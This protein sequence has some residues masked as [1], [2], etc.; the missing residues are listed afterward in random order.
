MWCESPLFLQVFSRDWNPK[1]L[2]FSFFDFQSNYWLDLAALLGIYAQYFSSSCGHSLLSVLYFFV[3]IA[4]VQV[5]YLGLDCPK[6]IIHLFKSSLYLQRNCSSSETVSLYVT[7]LT[8]YLCQI[9]LF[10]LKGPLRHKIHVKS[11]CTVSGNINQFYTLGCR[12]VSLVLVLCVPIVVG[13]PALATL[14]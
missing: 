5:L 4:H 12:Q 10:S 7:P 14:T 6:Y 11:E 8:S 9:V 3:P 1:W 13:Y 2:F